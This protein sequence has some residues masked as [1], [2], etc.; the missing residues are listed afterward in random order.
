[1]FIF[2]GCVKFVTIKV[3]IFNGLLLIVFYNVTH[4]KGVSSI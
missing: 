2:S 1:M 4:Y 3:F